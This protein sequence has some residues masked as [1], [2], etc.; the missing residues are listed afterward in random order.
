VIPLVKIELGFQ[1]LHLFGLEV[2][3]G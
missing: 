1:V 2:V 3:S